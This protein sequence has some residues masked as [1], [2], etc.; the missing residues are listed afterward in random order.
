M[1]HPAPLRSRPQRIVPPEKADARLKDFGMSVAVIRQSI[2]TGDTARRRV[3]FPHFPAIFAGITM[4]A[5]TLAAWRLAMLKR[6]LNYE[7]GKTRGY[8]TIYCVGLGVA[9]AVV[10]GDSYTGYA[11][12]R[13]PR[14]TREKGTVTIER[15]ARNRTASP[16]VMVQGALIP[17][18]TKELPPD[19]ACETWFLIV[20]PRASEIRIELSRP[21]LMDGG[22]VNGYSERILLAP[23]PIAGAVAPIA[24]DDDGGDDSDDGERLASR[25]DGTQVI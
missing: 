21:I 17:L 7:I 20:H 13:D 16:N 14:L 2:E 12:R 24:P 25:P 9:F 15:V 23:V 3:M 11:G 10:A 19:E 5:E 6:Q 1:T 18:P 22:I 4:W 8:E